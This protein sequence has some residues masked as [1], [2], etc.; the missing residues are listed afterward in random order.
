M[1]T[2]TKHPQKDWLTY[3]EVKRKI[4]AC[5]GTDGEYLLGLWIREPDPVLPRHYFPGRKWAA[6]PAQRVDEL[7]QPYQSNTTPT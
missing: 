1:T 6:Y 2:P 5:I 3:G 7:L 4:E